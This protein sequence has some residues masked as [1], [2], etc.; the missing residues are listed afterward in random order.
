MATEFARNKISESIFKSFLIAGSAIVLAAC[1]G[2]GG[3]NSAPTLSNSAISLSTA[4]DTQVSGAVTATDP[5]GDTLGYAIGTAP[6]NGSLTV[7]Q[8]GTFTYTPNDDYFGDDSATIVVSDSIE[9]VIATISVAV[10]N[11]NDLP[12]ITT[13]SLVVGSNGETTG[14]IE[15]SDIDGDA[16]SFAVQSQPQQGTVEI[17]SSTGAFTFTANELATVNDSFVV[18]VSDGIGDPVTA[19]ID[20]GASYASNEDKLTYYYASS[21]SHI[22]QAEAMIL[23]DGDSDAIQITDAEVAQD[24]YIKIAIGYAQA[25]FPELSRNIITDNIITRQSKA[26]AYQGAAVE[27]D[28][29]GIKD[30]AQSFRTAAIAEYNAYIAEI[31]L[32]NIGSSDTQFYRSMVEDYIE[33]NELG[34]A[35]DLLTI[36][37]IY[38]D[39]LSDLTQERTTAYNRFAILARALMASQVEAFAA[40]P[41]S[42]NYE[43]A[44]LAVN[45][46]EHIADTTSFDETRGILHFTSKALTLIESARS[47]Y[48]LSLQGNDEQKAVLIDKAK[49][50][51]AKGIALYVPADYDADYS[52]PVAEHADGTISRY[53]TGIGLLAG[54]FAALYPDYVAANTTDTQIGNLPLMLVEAEEGPTDRDTKNAYRDHF[55]YSLIPA[56]LNSEDLT[57]I[58]NELTATFTTTYD[59]TVL[60][61]EA[62]VEQD[63][64]GFIDK[65]AA[66]LL[67]YAGLDTQARQLLEAAIN[68]LGTDAYFND[69]GYTVDSIVENQGCARF[70]QLHSDFGGTEAEQTAL[71]GQ[72]LDL[73]STY[74]GND[75]SA[76]EVQRMH[77]WVN[78]AVI[79]NT[80]GNDNA[81]LAALTTA[82]GVVETQTDV[83]DLFSGRIY[84]ANTYASLGYLDAAAT[85]FSTLATDAMA[86]V[87]AATD[88]SERVDLVDDLLSEL[89]EAFEPDDANSFLNIDYLVLATKKHAGTNGQYPQAIASILATS[90]TLL[91]T[92]LAATNDFADSEKIDFYE[93]FIEQYAWI[94]QFESANALALNE[95]YTEAD[96]EPLFATVSETLA[97]RDDFPASVVANIDTDLDGL[98]NFFLLNASEEAITESNLIIDNDADD[99]GIEDPNDINPLDKD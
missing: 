42:A 34:S 84:L 71:Y 95:I 88:I 35:T 43:A 82:Q 63:D 93:T 10:S 78:A 86:R 18:S 4:E 51:L 3:G 32:A 20:L 83:D 72:C 19:T 69:A 61:V 36:L 31:G 37:R 96:R 48:A 16:L 13:S 77:A 81:A 41:S 60:V 98:P 99:D 40:D 57:P 7:N 67:H 44:L 91:D 59:D 94:G 97:S 65:R 80:I 68:T 76:S 8:D 6:N 52:L 11:V 25:G 30:I 75:T 89:E 47:A 46:A 50:L 29:I 53:P 79:Q 2:N 5:D 33:A 45:F 15:A 39:S 22:T 21:H 17:N 9:S 23:N 1:G 38:A 54:P 26:E 14:I 85:A 12:V 70:V 27:L 90:N 58:I 49:T 92:L 73:V 62:L 55:A 74:Y 66:W 64:N 87:A 24:A 56:A 28:D